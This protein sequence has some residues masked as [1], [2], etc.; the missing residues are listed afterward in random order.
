MI[1]ISQNLKKLVTHHSSLSAFMTNKTHS[2]MKKHHEFTETESHQTAKI[3]FFF[4]W[5]SSKIYC[6][7]FHNNFHTKQQHF[8]LSSAQQVLFHYFEVSQGT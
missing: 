7:L 4:K 8:T 3:F 6:R 2:G 1:Q 5:T